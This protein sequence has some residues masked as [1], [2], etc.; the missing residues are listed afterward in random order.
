M[1]RELKLVRRV[2]AGAGGW[3]GDAA[4][5]EGSPPV[6]AGGA[7]TE[8]GSPQ[9]SIPGSLAERTHVS[10]RGCAGYVRVTGA[11]AARVFELRIYVEWVRV[12]AGV[13]TP[14][15]RLLAADG[16]VVREISNGE[17]FTT[18]P[19]QLGDQRIAFH[20]TPVGGNLAQNSVVE[21]WASEI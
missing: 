15:W 20:L 11:D 18:D 1:A 4:W 3:G 8:V 12:E 16:G 6:A 21:I 13:R 10:A 2:T 9:F 17:D 5:S 14:D 19:A 7:H